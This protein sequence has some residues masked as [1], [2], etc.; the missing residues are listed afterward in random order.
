MLLFIPLITLIASCGGSAPIEPSWSEADS[1]VMKEHLYG[2]VLPYLAKEDLEV[3]YNEE[4]QELTISGGIIENGDL[5]DYASK[6]T[7]AL[8]WEGGDASSDYHK[9]EGTVF[10]FEKTVN[11]A[12]G[13]RFI[14]VLFYALDGSV[15][16][17]TGSFHLSAVDPYQYEYPEKDVSDFISE[18]FGSE[19]LPP[20]MSGVEYYEFS[21]RYACLSMYYQSTKA[22]GGYSKVLKDNNW[23]VKSELVDDYYYATSPDSKYV[24]RYLYLEQYGALDIYFDTNK[25]FPTSAINDFFTKYKVSG[26][27][28]PEFDGALGGFIFEEDENNQHYIDIGYPENIN[29]KI[30]CYGADNESYLAYVEKLYDNFWSTNPQDDYTTASYR[31]PTSLNRLTIQYKSEEEMTV[32]TIYGYLEPVGESSWPADRIKK[33]L[34]FGV[35]EEVPMFEGDAIGY[36]ILNDQYGTAVYVQVKE[37]TENQCV[38]DYKR[39]LEKYGYVFDHYDIYG[40]SYYKSPLGQIEVGVYFATTG[41]ITIPF[42][43]L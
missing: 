43:A 2:E 32:I 28:I 14:N 5:A 19:I 1:K 26:I 7:T 9:E 39:T 24:V 17:K 16:S 20:D 13:K 35:T 11:T 4:Y 42:A 8:G 15:V 33:L 22:D 31:L 25:E 27:S 23:T 29:A 40:D 3:T 30:Y 10:E 36:D 37:G 38:A 34:G 12:Q 6:Y 21:Y 41:S 18:C